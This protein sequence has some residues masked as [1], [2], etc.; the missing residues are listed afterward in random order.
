MALINAMNGL[1]RNPIRMLKIN[2]LCVKH[3]IEIKYP[4]PLICYNGWV[5]GFIDSDGFILLTGTVL[6]MTGLVTKRK[7]PVTS[8]GSISLN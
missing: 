2:K 8:D 6:V 3:G 1:I 5:S 7:P 4:K